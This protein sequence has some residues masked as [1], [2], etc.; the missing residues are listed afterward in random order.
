M[1]KLNQIIAIASGKKAS[2]IAAV[3]EIYKTLQKVDLFNGIK[4]V[5]QPL[6]EEGEKLPPETKI[7][8]QKVVNVLA[9]ASN[10]FA[11][12]FDVIAIQEY[13]NCKARAD[14]K[15]GETVIAQNVPVT[16]L[17]FLEKQLDNIKS[18][19]SKVPV[20]S[21]DV[22]WTR[23]ESDGTIYV[24][25]TIVTT[26]TKKLP[27]AF[28]KVPA[29]DKFPAQ[30]EVFN[31]DIIVGNWSK[32]DTS[33]AISIRERDAMLKKVDSLRD[34]VKIAREE[35]NSVSVDKVEIG[36]AVTSFIFG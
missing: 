4:R 23:S 34:A 16:Y 27:K 15:V 12:M 20:L 19:I 30:V 17:M 24:A 29:T 22:N 9:E 3:T 25:D 10:M 33:S 7:I 28:V 18:L 6:D 21:T 1:T 31:E 5:Y 14:I 2:C 26:R 11:D 13:A 32:T 36:K 8:Q 35:A